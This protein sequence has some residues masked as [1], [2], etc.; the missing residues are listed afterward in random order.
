LA[1]VAIEI[2]LNNEKKETI[3][4]YNNISMHLSSQS[5]KTQTHFNISMIFV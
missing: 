5:I 2:S 3:L 4:D 1:Q